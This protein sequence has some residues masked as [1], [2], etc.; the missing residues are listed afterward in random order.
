MISFLLAVLV[1]S[2]ALSGGW[3][4]RTRTY[5][6]FFRY[7]ARR[8]HCF[9]FSAQHAN[10]T[11]LQLAAGGFP[12]PGECGPA[13][14]ALLELR[15]DATLA[16]RS[17]EPWIEMRTRHFYARQ[18]FERGAKGARYLNL[19][20]LLSEPPQSGQ[21]IFLHGFGLAWRPQTA[22]L[23]CF[24]ND[25]PAQPRSV[26]IAPHPDDAEIAAFGLYRNSDSTV[27]TV[28][29]GDLGTFYRGK[30]PA[31][32]PRTAELTA[33]VR[34][35]DSI[36]AP[37]FGGVDPRR[38]I[39]LGYIDSTLADAFANPDKPITA[40]HRSIADIRRLNLS[41]LVE[42]ADVSN[43]WR[44]LVDDLVR[45]FTKTNPTLIATPHPLL[46]DHPDHAFSTI[47][48]CE[49]LERLGDRDG[50]LLLY[51]NHTPWS[52]LHPVGRNDGAISLPPHFGE[53]LPFR[54]IQ[55]LAL[56]DDDM[57]L[58]LLAIETHHDLRAL[59]G[60]A[61]GLVDMIRG[62]A[63]GVRDTITG[64]DRHA[65]SYF[66]RAVRPNELFFVV[67]FSEAATLREAFLE[68]WRAGKIEWHRSK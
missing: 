4:L 10:A 37:M 47:A 45:I 46:D 9:D 61:P 44:S 64:L 68:K 54:S 60:P 24:R 26:V 42:E 28:T 65:T 3:M 31:G 50:S 57:R 8:D 34:A 23:F 43:T 27:V 55:S 6:R 36:A 66:R 49:A 56:S 32:D 25:W 1:V 2:A 30:F 29:A 22:R 14:T 51:T 63:G 58:K 62:F 59:P 17:R 40:V 53:P 21:R 5:R 41:L 7:D 13:D 12:W 15:I 39:N 48:V 52:N 18:Y 67:P 35:W 11:E 20:A 19:S 16:G 38:A 33:R